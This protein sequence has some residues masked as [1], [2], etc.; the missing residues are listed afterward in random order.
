MPY[1]RPADAERW[2][3]GI[4]RPY[5]PTKN[6]TA[7]MERQTDNRYDRQTS[8]PG[9]GVEGQRRLHR[10]RVLIVGVGGLGCPVALYLAA[11]GVGT[12]GL[13]DDDKVSLSNLQRQVLYTEDEVGRPKVTC[14][15]HRL[16]AL[17]SDLEIRPYLVR[18]T[19]ENA[20]KLIS[21]YDVVV[22]GCDN[23]AT[24]YLLSD[25][26]TLLGKPYVYA[27]IGGFEGQVSVLCHGQDAPTYR[28][29]FPDEAAMA[30]IPVDRSVV[31]CVPGVVGS[32]EASE[33]LKLLTGR[34]TPLAGRLWTI[35]LR[36]MQT[37]LLQI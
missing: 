9:F 34:G 26:C 7:M 18:L 4:D 3:N 21:P 36:T 13:V 8:L 22:D 5:N 6:D 14:A 33:V 29:L 17:N 20:T 16:H 11:A 27:A 2:Q 37:N 30:D 10:S 12:L 28:T 1:D 35:D 25:T 32:V 31:G 24:R 23:Y 19:A 15:V